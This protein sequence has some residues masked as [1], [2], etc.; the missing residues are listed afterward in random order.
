[1]D[2]SIETTIIVGKSVAREMKRRRFCSEN[3]LDEIETG[4]REQLRQVRIV[5]LKE[6]LEE[7]VVRSKKWT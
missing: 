5:G 4:L 1:M 6:F 3:S 2:F 7:Y